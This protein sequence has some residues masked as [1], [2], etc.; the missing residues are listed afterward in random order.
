MDDYSDEY[1]GWLN[2]EEVLRYRKPKSFPTNRDE[3]LE[4][5]SNCNNKITICLGIFR[6]DDNRHIGNISLNN[7]QWTHRSCELSILIG[8]KSSW[9]KGY[10]K[11][12]ISTIT[13]HA[14]NSMGMH[15]VW[16]ESANPAFIKSVVGLGWVKEGIKREAFLLDGKF[17]DF[18]CYSLIDK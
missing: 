3:A 1:L 7:I 14:F 2:D 11:E 16:A 17:V 13:N 5:L 8:D 4:F 18:E 12:A 15:R 10:G 9:G 6:K